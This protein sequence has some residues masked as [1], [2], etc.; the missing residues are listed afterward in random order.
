MSS[1]KNYKLE[2]SPP[3][4]ESPAKSRNLLK[5]TVKHH[6]SKKLEVFKYLFLTL[7]VSIFIAYITYNLENIIE[8]RL[9]IYQYGTIV[10]LIALI[11]L[12][13]LLQTPE[14][15]II[16]MKG[17][18]VQLQS[19]KLWKFQSSDSFIPIDNIIDLVIHEGFHDY[20]QVIFY[21]CI[22]TK[23][24]NDENSITVLFPEFL[25]RK[26]ILLTVWTLSRDLL[27][28]STQRY[29]RRVP[30][31]GLKQVV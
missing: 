28:G 3:L 29:W 16:V 26:D 15:S 17:I 10:V 19:K 22:L 20:G 7:T 14:D 24:N 5:F 31:Q 18:G 2:I 13:S 21:L 9:D 30:G 1:L 8:G 6:S 25:P 11:G 27:F 23:A 12:F 4:H